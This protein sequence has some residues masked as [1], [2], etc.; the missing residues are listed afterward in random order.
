[1]LLRDQEELGMTFRK[2]SIKIN[3]KFHLKQNLFIENFTSNIWAENCKYDE[4]LCFEM[5]IFT[6]STLQKPRGKNVL[7]M[8]EVKP[9]KW[10]FLEKFEK[11]PQNQ[12]FYFWKIFFP[13]SVDV[14]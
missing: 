8:E 10:K 12:F 7:K 2:F 9:S 13:F 14:L 11:I 3:V 4:K 5:D 1:M 6:Q